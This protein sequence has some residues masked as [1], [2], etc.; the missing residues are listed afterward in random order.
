MA[1]KYRDRKCPYCEHGVSDS[2][3]HVLS[4]KFFAVEDR[5]NLPKVPACM[6][7][8]GLKANLERYALEVLPFGAR[9]HAAKVTLER[10]VPRRLLANQA[11]FRKMNEGRG[12]AWVRE[13]P[14]GLIVPTMTVPVD[15]FRLK[16]LFGYIV[17]GLMFHHWATYLEAGDPVQVMFLTGEGNQRFREDFAQVDCEVLER[18]YGRGTFHYIVFR[19]RKLAQTTAWLFSI[20]GG[21]C[22]ASGDPADG[23]SSTMVAFTGT[24]EE[25]SPLITE[26][27]RHSL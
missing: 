14:D 8:N 15:A 16:S 2:D 4:R 25:T 1:R 27:G 6:K 11:H 3:E 20:L 24:E 7:C 26:T 21:V 22:L 9:H 10:E 19:D 17:R 18:D 23:V 12:K 5:G 13:R